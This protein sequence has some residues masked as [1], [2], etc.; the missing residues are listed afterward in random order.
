MCQSTLHA[1]HS[2]VLDVQVQHH[3][4]FHCGRGLQGKEAEQEGVK[5]AQLTE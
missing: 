5:E 4:G 1:V 2:V 3:E